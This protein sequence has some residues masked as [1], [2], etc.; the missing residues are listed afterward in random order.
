[1]TCAPSCHQKN[2]SL[3]ACSGLERMVWIK[4]PRRCT[5]LRGTPGRGGPR[6]TTSASRRPRRPSG[7]SSIAWAA[8]TA[9]STCPPWRCSTRARPP[10]S[11]CVLLTCLVAPL[12]GLTPLR[13]P[14][15]Q[16]V[17]AGP[18]LTP[19]QWPHNHSA[20]LPVLCE[21]LGPACTVQAARA[22]DL[23]HFSLTKTIDTGQPH[24]LKCLCQLSRW[25]KPRAVFA[26]DID[27]VAA[28]SAS[29]NTQET[30]WMRAVAVI[31]STD[32]QAGVFDC[33]MARLRVQVAP[34]HKKR[35]SHVCT[36]A[37]GE[38]Y[39]LG[40][41]DASNYMHAVR[42]AFPVA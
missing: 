4:S 28:L 40:G 35:G 39:A 3:I 37:N 13:A 36:V 41:W 30:C 8:S 5:P 21:G 11:W 7:A 1:M 34:M 31:I 22:R 42:L 6:C 20:V 25:C 29:S 23:L 18:V 10:G 19:L 32:T 38:V 9:R 14:S 15:W 27:D 17:R 16:L 12:F 2:S 24:H 33:C 26:S